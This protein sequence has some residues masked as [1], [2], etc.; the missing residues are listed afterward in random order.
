[1]EKRIVNTAV[2]ANVISLNDIVTLYGSK[3]RRHLKHVRSNKSCF[4]FAYVFLK[5]T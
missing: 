1:M 5:K 3:E 2:V 4:I